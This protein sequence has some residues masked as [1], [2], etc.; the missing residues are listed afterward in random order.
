MITP[1]RQTKTATIHNVTVKWRNQKLEVRTLS[2]YYLLNNY[3]HSH[4]VC[5][6][7]NQQAPFTPDTF[8]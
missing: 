1:H 7:Q 2:V 6:H 3:I 8:D 4:R 5:S